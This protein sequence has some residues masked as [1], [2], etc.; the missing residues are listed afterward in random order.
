MD[1]LSTPTVSADVAQRLRALIHGGHLG[2]GDRLPPEREL[3]KQM[4]VG[5]VSI[6]EALR[7]LQATG[8]VDVRRGASGGTFIT[9]LDRPYEDWV[10]RMRE[11]VEEVNDILDLRVG[12]EGRAATLAAHR[13]NDAQLAAMATAIEELTS[14]DSRTSFRNSDARFHSALA[15]AS[16][17]KRLEVAI[18]QARGEMFAPVDQ[19]GFTE[20]IETSRAAHT[21]IY[22]AVRDRDPHRAAAAMEA[23]LEETRGE[24]NELIF[25]ER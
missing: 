5:R 6:R 7:L 15:Q 18:E 11:S 10:R 13:R 2:P 17:S 20:V 19:G 16:G 9:A 1:Q 23:H 24:L 12:L 22:E 25:G 21:A 14:A 4:G 3:A 8:Y